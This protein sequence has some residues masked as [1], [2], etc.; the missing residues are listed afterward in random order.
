MTSKKALVVVDLQNDFCPGGALPVRGGDEIVAPVNA[1]LASFEE[2]SLP[3]VL[4]RDWHPKEHSSF[5]A[6]GGLWA[7]HCVQHTHGAEFHPSLRVPAG[8]M[9]IS[10]A[11]RKNEEAYSGFQ[12]TDLAARLR[13]A[14]VKELFVCGLATDYCVKNTV[15]D[16]L[17]LGFT[18]Y[19]VTDCVR[20]LKQKDSSEA[21][22]AMVARGAAKTT[23]ARL[24]KEIGRRVAM[25]SSS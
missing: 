8:A 7:P 23:S 12:G 6:G 18:A 16:A 1:L 9:V 11:T 15:L 14:G 5:Q 20:S 4:T 3:I 21:L 25:S 24:L 19:V 10:K 17:G 13:R 22:S 2:A